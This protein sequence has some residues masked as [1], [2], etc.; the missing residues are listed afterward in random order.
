MADRLT[1]EQLSEIEAAFKMYDT[2]GD[3]QISAEELGQAM[4]EA[5]Q[6][7]SD[8]ELK[9]MIRAVDLDGNGK[10]EFKEF[11]QMMANQLGQP[12]PV[13]EMK[14]YFD[15]FDQDGNGFIDSDEMKCLVR[16]FYSNLTGDAL[17]QQ[18][19]AMIEAA[20]TN[21]DGKISFEEFV[22]VLN[23]NA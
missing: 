13:E 11:V 14:A 20:D 7:V 19:R 17:K 12:A 2:N 18:V 10:V 3:G 23:A 4:R 22:K 6:L 5:G 8:E 21:S 16:A 1:P 15:R 9:D